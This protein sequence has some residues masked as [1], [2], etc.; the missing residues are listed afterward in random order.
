[1]D[2]ARRLR[3]ELRDKGFEVELVVARV[4][5]KRWNRVLAGRSEHRAGA[6]ALVP[7]LKKAG[8]RDLLVMKAQ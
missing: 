7:Q 3:D 4:E 2:N 5:G 8:Y 1:P 6:Q